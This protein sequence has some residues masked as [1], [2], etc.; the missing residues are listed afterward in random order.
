MTYDSKISFFFNFSGAGKPED[1]PDAEAARWAFGGSDDLHESDYAAGYS[2]RYYP[3]AD[4]RSLTV[5]QAYLAFN[6]VENVEANEDLLSALVVMNANEGYRLRV[7]ADEG[8]YLLA[9]AEFS[10]DIPF[11]RSATDGMRV[12]LERIGVTAPVNDSISLVGFGG[13]AEAGIP[14]M[15]AEQRIAI[16]AAPTDPEAEETQFA[17]A[18]RQGVDFIERPA[19]GSFEANTYVHTETALRALGRQSLD[20]ALSDELTKLI[21]KHVPEE[22][23]D[24]ILECVAEPRPGLGR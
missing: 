2:D 7:S 22:V 17:M 9:D 18:S 16:V 19:F 3:L 13:K 15:L 12:S 23:W 21:E 20:G 14:N 4:R 6:R 24:L 5:S 11:F 1:L 10:G 8:T